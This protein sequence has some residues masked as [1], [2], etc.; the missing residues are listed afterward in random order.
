MRRGSLSAGKDPFTLF[1]SVTMGQT[2]II[3]KI[4]ATLRALP[5]RE[6]V[7]MTSLL[8]LSH[9]DG[10]SSHRGGTPSGNEALTS[11]LTKELCKGLARATAAEH[12]ALLLQLAELNAPLWQPELQ[13]QGALAL[14][15]KMSTTAS[16]ETLESVLKA[17]LELRS[18]E[19]TE[20]IRATSTILIQK[21]ASL[22][23][24]EE[25]TQVRLVSLLETLTLLEQPACLATAKFLAA[26]CQVIQNTKSDGLLLCVC[27]VLHRLHAS[28]V[29]GDACAIQKIEKSLL[30]V[31]VRRVES[32][33]VKF[34]KTLASAKPPSTNAHEQ[35]F[36]RLQCESFLKPIKTK[37][38]F[39]TL[40]GLT[41]SDRKRRIPTV[42]TLGELTS[43]CKTLTQIQYYPK[44]LVT[45]FLQLLQNPAD[46][47]S[48]NMTVDDASYIVYVALRAGCADKVVPAVIR[49]ALGGQR[50]RA[51]RVSGKRFITNRNTEETATGQS[52]DTPSVESIHRQRLLV[53]IFIA[54]SDLQL[55]WVEDSESRVKLLLAAAKFGRLDY[56][57]MMRHMTS[58][59]G[60]NASATSK[61]LVLSSAL[62]QTPVLVSPLMSCS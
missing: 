32:D 62:R 44:D 2:N 16:M 25:P 29:S 1:A 15:K 59:G 18:V 55:N 4:E 37:N 14:V 35:L 26:L 12:D 5:P 21:Y 56:F 60:N 45:H 33:Y 22:K 9:A 10:R 50:T 3:Q 28:K 30:A 34:R 48:E 61:R 17:L 13:S 58:V 36:H 23:V 20:W 51:F 6:V 19:N 8:W 41:K 47:V 38:E 42:D 53:L 46:G 31:T 43:V 49:A 11:A 52:G 39:S 24:T 7:R 40:F 54:Q 27:M 57:Y